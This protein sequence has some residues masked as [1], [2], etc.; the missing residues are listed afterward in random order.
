MPRGREAILVG[1]NPLTTK[2][3]RIY[4]PDLRRV[5]KASSIVFN[6]NTPGGEIDL[7]LKT[8][9]P[10]V[11]PTRKPIGRPKLNTDSV[12]VTKHQGKSISSTESRTQKKSIPTI[13]SN[14]LTKN[15]VE[16]SPITELRP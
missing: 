10:N 5:I 14:T 16:S 1:F 9:T 12:S 6:K 13:E 3:Y 15:Q 4:T 2:Q 8:I 11:L 7:N